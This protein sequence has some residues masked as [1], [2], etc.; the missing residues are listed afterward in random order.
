MELLFFLEHF[1]M[2]CAICADVH[3]SRRGY[4]RFANVHSEN[5]PQVCCLKEHINARTYYQVSSVLHLSKN[6]WI[7][8]HLLQNSMKDTFQDSSPPVMAYNTIPAPYG[9]PTTQDINLKNLLVLI[10]S[11]LLLFGAGLSHCVPDQLVEH[12]EKLKK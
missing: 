5:C 7:A 2:H 10:W 4:A 11:D 12:L 3:F 6:N 9:T 1:Y 8:M